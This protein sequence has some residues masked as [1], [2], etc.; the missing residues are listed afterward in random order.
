MSASSPRPSVVQH[1]GRPAFAGP[2]L[3]RRMSR[4]AATALLLPACA[5]AVACGGRGGPPFVARDSAGVRIAES[6]APAWGE[7]QGFTVSDT[8]ELSI[9]VVRGDSAYQLYQVRG[10]TRL[11]DGT[12]VV[13][14]GGTQELR[15]YDASGKFVRAAGGR[16]GAPGEFQALLEMVRIPGD[17]IIAFDWRLR[18]L[19]LFG[20]HGGLARTVSLAS[21]AGKA[22]LMLAGAL[23]GGR[24]L[25]MRESV[26]GPGSIPEGYARDTMRLVELDDSAARTADL[27][28]FPGGERFVQITRRNG[29][30]ASMQM[31]T[32]PFSRNAYVAVGGGRVW[33]GSS[34]RYEIRAFGPGGKLLEIVRRTDM[35]PKPVTDAMKSR[36]VEAR[37]A[38]RKR[39]SPNLSASDLA[40]ARKVLAALPAPPTEP[41]FTTLRV[42]PRGDLWVSDFRPPWSHDDPSTWSVFAPDGR[43][44]GTVTVPAGLD[45]YDVGR[46]YVLGLRKDDL[47]VEHVEMYALSRKE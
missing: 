36:A 8:P 11:S 28:P 41:A 39:D 14:D 24:F 23:D 45:V 18:R 3:R 17:S 12:I 43:W 22:P 32:L 1:P 21:D 20:P 37:L 26:L 13:A 6:R 2:R 33:A 5:L 42:D 10:A 35:T 30:I 25:A 19:S 44:L 46:D 38:S 9:G 34:D 29:K 31:M 7:R 15:Y 4:A 40:A 27:G 16:G 47:G